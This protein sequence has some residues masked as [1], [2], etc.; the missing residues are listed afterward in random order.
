MNT[1]QKIKLQDTH[2]Y[3]LTFTKETTENYAKLTGDYNLAHM[4][5]EYAKTTI[6]KDRI[7]HGMLVAS[8]FS[9]IFGM[10]Y[11]GLGSIY[12]RQN[13]KFKRPVYF[14]DTIEAKVIVREINY[15]RNRVVFD[16]VS[17]NQ[18]GEVVI[19]GE[20][21]IMPPKEESNQ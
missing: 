6:F 21:E 8:M 9:K 10:D 2:S 13:I 17:I 19:E 15:E 18:R 12:I 11:P 5:I 1:I 20:A 3:T 4:D 7:V 14:E 16:C